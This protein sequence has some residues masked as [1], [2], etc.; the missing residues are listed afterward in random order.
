VHDPHANADEAHEEYG[1]TLDG[2]AL[3]RSYDAVFAAVP[4]REYAALTVAK[5]EALIRPGGLL[6]DLKRLWS[7][8]ASGT[9]TLAGE[10]RYRGL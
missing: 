2:A 8:L 7:D 6:F 9:A 4:H 10:R 1:L 5:L 3:D